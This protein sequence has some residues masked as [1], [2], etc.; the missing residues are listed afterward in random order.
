M[1]NFEMSEVL[2]L[3]RDINGKRRTCTFNGFTDAARNVNNLIEEDDEIQSVVIN[4]QIVWTALAGE[5]LNVDDL[6]GFFG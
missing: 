4:N 1:Y 6:T 3:V 2:I 5:P